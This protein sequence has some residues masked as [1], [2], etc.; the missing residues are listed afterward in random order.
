[1]LPNPAAVLAVRSDGVYLE[2]GVVQ[3]LEVGGVAGEQ[4]K[5][6]GEGDRGDQEGDGCQLPPARYCAEPRG[7]VAELSSAPSRLSTNVATPV[8]LDTTGSAANL[9]VGRH[10]R[11]DRFVT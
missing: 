4:R 8:A 2:P 6:V 3:V 11:D 7:G 1:V 9:S 5:V 10:R